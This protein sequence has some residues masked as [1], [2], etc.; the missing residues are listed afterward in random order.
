MFCRG[1]TDSCPQIARHAYL[2]RNLP[3]RKFF[4]QI[5]ILTGTET[6]ADALRMEIE[7]SPDR[8][9]RSCL[10]G[11][12]GQP[13]PV[14]LGICV[15]RAEKFRRSFLLVPSYADANDVPVFVTHSQLED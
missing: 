11:V 4:D 12:S 3:I 7:R 15:G 8:F 10:A 5:R 1:C 13:Q 6:V 9:R 14:I 2:Y